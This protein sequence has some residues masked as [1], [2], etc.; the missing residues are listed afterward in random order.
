[1]AN[2]GKVLLIE[3][4]KF[5]RNLLVR[6]LEEAGFAVSVAVNGKEGLE[7]NKEEKPDLILL[8][9]ILPDIDGFELI[10][11]FKEDPVTSSIPV[12]FLTNLGQ[13]DELKKGLALGAADYLV[14]AHFTPEEITK[15]IEKLLTIIP[16]P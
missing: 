16:F 2:K 1:M 8:D 6:K 10:R 14:K 3:D 4:D 13:E 7:K 12:I 11:Q 15:K 9:I 5:L